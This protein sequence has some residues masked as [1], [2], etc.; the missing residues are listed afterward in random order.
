[1]ANVQQIKR[2]AHKAFAGLMAL[3]L[4]GFVFLI[5]CHAQSDDAN[6]CPLMKLGA[7]CDLAEQAKNAEKVTHQTNDD[8]LDC[9]AFIPAF[10]DKTRTNEG[11]QQIATNAPAVVAE[12]PRPVSFRTNFAP[13]PS[14]VSTSLLRND[15]FLKNRTF[16]I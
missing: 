7:H 5:A 11:H 15:T 8:G 1:M 12:Q 6:V 16:R 3:W 2:V 13:F 10:F 4:S 14:Y 9:C